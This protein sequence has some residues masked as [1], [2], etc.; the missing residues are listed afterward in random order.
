[1]LAKIFNFIKGHET[2]IVLAAVIVLI[3]IT[4]YN[5]GKIIAYRSIKTPIVITEPQDIV[6]RETG[7]GNNQAAN[8]QSAA[9]PRDLT[10]VA[11]KK[12]ASKLYHFTWCPGAKQISAANKISFSNETAAI[13]AGYTL[14]GNCRK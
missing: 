13:A 4:S 8:I 1:M 11:S 5:V 3:T 10:V 12:S 14:A 9:G 6:R 7:Q 2:D